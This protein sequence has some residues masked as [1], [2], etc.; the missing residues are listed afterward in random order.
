MNS[1]TDAGWI[2]PAELFRQYV[3]M[4]VY[5][6]REIFLTPVQ[7]G[8]RLDRHE[9]AIRRSCEEG[10]LPCFKFGGRILIH[11]PSVFDHPERVLTT[12]GESGPPNGSSTNA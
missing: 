11:W 8:R 9:G 10:R 3:K 12:P 1:D 2:S 6:R 5:T 4:K 7:V